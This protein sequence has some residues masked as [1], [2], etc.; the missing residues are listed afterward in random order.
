MT[1]IKNT[2]IFLLK[3]S[4]KY[5]LK[6]SKSPY[7]VFIEKKVGHDKKLVGSIYIDL[8]KNEVEKLKSIKKPSLVSLNVYSQD[9]QKPS[10]AK[11][12]YII[13]YKIYRTKF[14]V[15]ITNAAYLT[16]A[17]ADIIINK[18]NELGVDDEYFNIKKADFS[19]IY[20]L[21]N[22]IPFSGSHTVHKD[23]NLP[24]VDKKENVPRLIEYKNIISI[25]EKV[26]EIQKNRSSKS[27]NK[28]AAP[29]KSPVQPSDVRNR[30]TEFFDAKSDINRLL[31]QIID[32]HSQSLS[33]S[34]KKEKEPGDITDKKKQKKEDSKSGTQEKKREKIDLLVDKIISFDD[35]VEVQKDIIDYFLPVKIK[36]STLL[37]QIVSAYN[38]K[39]KNID[40]TIKN[41]KTTSKKSSK[42]VKD[43][44]RYE[45]VYYDK[46][47]NIKKGIV[48][49]SKKEAEVAYKTIADNKKK[50]DEY[51]DYLSDKLKED[52][53]YI[54]KEIKK[55]QDDPNYEPNLKT[56]YSFGLI[57]I[58]KLK[59]D[60]VSE[61]SSTGGGAAPG[62]GATAV[63]G[64][65]EGMAT[66][67]A[68]SG[69][70]GTEAKRKKGIIVKNKI[71]TI[72]SENFSGLKN[73]A[74]MIFWETLRGFKK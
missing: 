51:E 40:D 12:L 38:K 21:L 17:E 65:G 52:P 15:S 71:K 13:T 8:D 4:S 66:K 68:F 1:N 23:K 64:G 61:M 3:E 30:A 72:K 73:D 34:D 26:K 19:E 57:N 7:R 55:S 42:K 53:K 69:A 44:D 56:K 62:T 16:E 48:S 67:Y 39:V 54:E 9:K 6:E 35:N 32:Y 63:T 50:Y 41:T 28:R 24:N 60:E 2:F 29:K 43:P 36:Y 49:F 18:K 25:I 11:D 14:F 59:N 5:I 10:D 74:K 47:E 37:S 27:N 20:D 31:Q 46:N 70:G 33:R 58:R 22:D 45:V